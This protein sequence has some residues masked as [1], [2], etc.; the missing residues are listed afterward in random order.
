MIRHLFYLIIALVF[1]L[2]SC[3]E[4]LVYD[5]NIPVRVH[6]WD[7][8]DTIKF[9]AEIMDT[10]EAYDLSLNIRHRDVYEYMNLYIKVNSTLPSGIQ[11][12]EVISLPLCDDAG[13][14]FGKCA[15]DICFQRVGLMRRVKFPEKGTYKFAINHEMRIKEI[16]DILDLGLRIE[17]SIN[18]N[19][20][21][22]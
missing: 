13:K 20:V 19:R 8:N 1:S 22:E 17:K 7:L 18:N 2:S 6:G 21:N 9:E 16:P 3:Q 10:V 15:G 14:W 5:V 4:E 12:T 11:K